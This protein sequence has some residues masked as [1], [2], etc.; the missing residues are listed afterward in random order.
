MSQFKKTSTQPNRL[1]SQRLW[2][3]EK[4][5]LHGQAVANSD[6]QWTEKRGGRGQTEGDGDREREVIGS[7]SHLRTW[8]SALSPPL[9]DLPRWWAATSS[10]R[11]KCSLLLCTSQASELVFWVTL[12]WWSRWHVR[13]CAV[14]HVGCVA[15]VSEKQLKTTNRQ[16]RLPEQNWWGEE[17]S[18]DWERRSEV[19]VEI[20]TWI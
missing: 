3:G 6:Q 10:P 5:K 4:C 8:V 12:P 15:L 19:T 13:V 17:I 18:V 2:E 16:T 7:Q 11:V 1:L 9:T 14:L 20:S